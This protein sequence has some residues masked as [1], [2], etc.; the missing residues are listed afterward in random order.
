[1]ISR[2]LWLLMGLLVLH[3]FYLRPQ[4]G[5]DQALLARAEK[6]AARIKREES[7]LNYQKEITATLAKNHE[8]I[9]HNS[10]LLYPASAN[11]SSVLGQFEEHIRRLAKETGVSLAHTR[12]GEP[13]IM[14]DA[15]YIRLPLSVA[16]QGDAARTGKFLA[17]LAQAHPLVAVQTARVNGLRE[18]VL[19]TN[20]ILLAFQATEA[21]D[22]AES[23]KQPSPPAAEAAPAAKP[24]APTGSQ[25]DMG[26]ALKGT[27]PPPGWPAD[28]PWPP[29][30]MPGKPP[31]NGR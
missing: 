30:V 28:E 6:L 16:I 31:R 27:P 12:W 14:E 29:K 2:T 24:A 18:E 7:L 1:M 11:S 9:R 5:E 23:E 19:N 20:L 25:P 4:A 8:Q 10:R 13:E 17:R 15:A 26:A 21:L 22:L 3:V